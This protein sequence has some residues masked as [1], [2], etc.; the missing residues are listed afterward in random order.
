[1]RTDKSERTFVLITL[2]AALAMA[3]I[4]S[5]WA[6]SFPD[7]LEKVAEQMGFLHRAEVKPAWEHSPMPDYAVPGVRSE[8]LST[9]LAGL[10]GTLMVFGIASVLGWGLIRLRHR[11]D[12]GSEE[13]RASDLH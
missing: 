10:L 1:M 5:P 2:L 6:S 12:R 11:R 4:L 9:G 8:A 3:A 13:Q 7:G